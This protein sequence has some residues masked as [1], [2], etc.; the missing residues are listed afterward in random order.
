M[1][2][3]QKWQDWITTLVDPVKKGEVRYFDLA[4]RDA[5]LQW[6]G[7]DYGDREDSTGT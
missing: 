2:G 6:L 4:D 7:Y 3:D 5:A 1:V